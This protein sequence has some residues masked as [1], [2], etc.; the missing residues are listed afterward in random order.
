ML[1][2]NTLP[3]TSFD[4]F[5]HVAVQAAVLLYY[6]N[7]FIIRYARFLSL[8]H[9]RLKALRKLVAPAKRRLVDSN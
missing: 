1:I 2:Q 5:M 3:N 8:R 6:I 7:S 9:R 4:L